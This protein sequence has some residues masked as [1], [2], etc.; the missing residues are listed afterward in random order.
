[1]AKAGANTC[2]KQTKSAYRNPIY[3]RTAQKHGGEVPAA[4]SCRS[5]QAGH[6]GFS[7]PLRYFVFQ[8]CD[9]VFD[10]YD[11]VFDFYHL[12]FQ[13]CDLVL[14]LYD[15]VFQLCDLVLQLY[16]LVFDFYDLVFQLCD[17]VF[18]FYDFLV[19]L[20]DLLQEKVTSKNDRWR[21][22]KKVCK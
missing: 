4:G 3:F 15:L 13:L 1:M 7:I 14:E 18:D 6:K 17:L 19:Q 22:S 20:C 12:V 5:P 10:F 16:N 9:L 21:V 11:L 2:P 8:L